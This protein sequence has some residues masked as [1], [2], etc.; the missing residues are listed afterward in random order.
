MSKIPLTCLLAL[1]GASAGA[2]NGLNVSPDTATGARFASERSV[3][4]GLGGF[5]LDLSVAQPGTANSRARLLGDY[6]LTGPGFG[7]AEVS[8]G[9]RVTSGLSFGPREATMAL[10][11]ARLGDGLR[12]GPLE[13]ATLPSERPGAQVALPYIGLGYTSLSA[14]EGWGLS[15]DIGLGGLRSGERVRFGAGNPTAA[16]FE[17]V[18]NSLRLAPVIQLGVSYAF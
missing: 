9:L 16:Q 14:R 10:P 13:P 1:L 6:Y 7:G 18:L 3:R 4:F 17:D 12:W 5:Q 15:A 11:A 2:Q 8:G